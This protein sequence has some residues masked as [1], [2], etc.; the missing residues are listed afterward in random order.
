M[1]TPGR[2][3]ARNRGAACGDSS[4][5]DFPTL[6]EAVG[7]FCKDMLRLRDQLH[8]AHQEICRLKKELGQKTVPSRPSRLPG[9]TKL[10]ALRRQVSFYCHPDRGGDE[11]LMQNMNALFD[12]LESCERGLEIPIHAA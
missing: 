4:P 8:E 3:D 10:R 5:E 6:S 2:G 9:Q 11:R 12:Y 1:S 7:A